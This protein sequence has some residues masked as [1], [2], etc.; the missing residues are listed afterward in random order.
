MEWLEFLDSMAI[1]HGLTSETL[2]KIFPQAHEKPVE[3]KVVAEKLHLQEE[4]VKARMTK[5]YEKFR[6]I[7]P[8][9]EAHQGQGKALILHQFLREKYAEERNNLPP[10]PES[11]ITGFEPLI[12]AKTKR[13]C[14][15]LENLPQT[16]ITSKLNFQNQYN[17]S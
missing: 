9:L 3:V 16:V 6:E 14:G 12:E 15:F 13:F 4:S 7:C 8:Q 10:Q 11:L 5:I 17:L 2:K 1:Q